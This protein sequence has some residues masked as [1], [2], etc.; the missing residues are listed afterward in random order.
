MNK[1]TIE[2][3]I[4]LGLAL[5]CKIASHQH[6][7]R[8]NYF[9]PDLPKGYQITQDTTPICTGGFVD[10]KLENGEVKHIGIT[11]IHMEEDAGKSIHDVDVYDTLV[12][13]NRAGTPLL[14]I[15]TEPDMRSADE[16]YAYLTEIRQLVRYLDICDGNMEEGSLRCDA[17]I[18]IRPMGETRLGIRTE[19]KNM[20]SFRN[21]Q[22]ALEFEVRRQRD[23]LL[24]GGHVA[25]QTLLWN[26]DTGQTESMRGKEEAHDYR[27]FPDPDLIP[28]VLDEVWIATIREQLPEL[29]DTRRLRFVREFELSDY[30]ADILTASRELADY[31]E[32]A[33]RQSGNAKKLAN[34]IGTEVLREYG[35]ERISECP[36]RPGQLAKLLLLIEDGTISGKIAKTVFAE[37]LTS[38]VDP[39]QIVKDKGLVQMSDEGQLVALVQEII[40]A[41]PEQVQQFREGK[42]KV[43]GFFV[44]QLMQKTKGQANPQMA[45]KLFQQELNR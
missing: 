9:Y 40:A 7:A 33:Y 35:P 25:Q 15:V 30:D 41:N 29:P 16:A 23:L 36:V 12:D 27:Y 8:K 44:G 32:E 31:F 5:N 1:K 20:N 18:S 45:N 42:T 10:V 13:L 17:N 38:G 39:E 37:M 22:L 43:M 21:V 14:E 6:F 2:F 4:K 3:A 28:V 11:R 24:E 19:L 26:P 34:F